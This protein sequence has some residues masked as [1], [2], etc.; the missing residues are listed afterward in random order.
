MLKPK[1]M[2]NFK[3]GDIVSNVVKT[4]KQL[5]VVLTDP[6]SIKNSL[7]QDIVYYIKVMWL[8]KIGWGQI[9]TISS[10]PDRGDCLW[11]HHY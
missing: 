4:N 6:I 3:P 2:R 8:G 7:K 1:E 9:Y 10:L 11:L 5:V